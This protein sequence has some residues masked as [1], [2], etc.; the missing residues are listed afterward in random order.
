MDIHNFTR[1][2]F[3]WSGLFRSLNRDA[4][5]E[6]PLVTSMARTFA[7]HHSVFYGRWQRKGENANWTTRQDQCAVNDGRGWVIGLL[8]CVHICTGKTKGI[9]AA[10]EKFYD[11][12]YLDASSATLWVGRRRTGQTLTPKKNLH[13]PNFQILLCRSVAPGANI[14]PEKKFS[15]G[16]NIFEQFL[17][18]F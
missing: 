18:I 7:H 1:L 6:P 4:C 15:G 16:Y 11:F 9:G 5:H 13:F 8:P 10:G 14:N 17:I 12:H 2:P 3:S